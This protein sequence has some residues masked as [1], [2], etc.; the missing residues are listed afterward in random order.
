MPLHSEVLFF[1]A[2]KVHI[3]VLKYV[4]SDFQSFGDRL[5]CTKE[6]LRFLL[7]QTKS[8]VDYVNEPYFFLA[9]ENTPT[10]YVLKDTKNSEGI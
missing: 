3:E 6:L 10:R 9:T 5:E 7:C 4:V 2:S 1:F 8:F